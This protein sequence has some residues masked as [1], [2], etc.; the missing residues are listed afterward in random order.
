MHRIFNTGLMTDAEILCIVYHE[1]DLD[2]QNRVFLTGAMKNSKI[3][4]SKSLR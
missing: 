1:V 2:E 3:Q 4:K